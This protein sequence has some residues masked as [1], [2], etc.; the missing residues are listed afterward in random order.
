M[1]I[2]PR[3]I[4][5]RQGAN[6]IH[7]SIWRHLKKLSDGSHSDKFESQRA[8]RSGVSSATF[9]GKFLSFKGK[10]PATF[11]PVSLHL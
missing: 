7:I 6:P 8:C 1:G 10:T 2:A 3:R 9:G 11:L 4:V 5:P